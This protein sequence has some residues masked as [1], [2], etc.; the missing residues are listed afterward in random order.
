MDQ[1]LQVQVVAPDVKEKKEIPVHL[2]VMVAQVAQD[3]QDLQDQLVD[4]V[5]LDLMVH[6]VKMEVEVLTV[7]QALWGQ[8]VQLV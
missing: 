7:A 8:L 5:V 6:Q 4:P 2:V 3:L 1:D